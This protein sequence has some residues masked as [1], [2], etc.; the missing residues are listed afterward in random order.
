MSCARAA[1][2]GRIDGGS[3]DCAADAADHSGSSFT[4][5]VQVV[6]GWMADRGLACRV[7]ELNREP[8]RSGLRACGRDM[9]IIP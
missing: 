3:A 2:N 9:I 1:A 8:G 6:G 7:Q 5:Q 4:S